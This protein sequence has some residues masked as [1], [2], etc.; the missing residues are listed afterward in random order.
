MMASWRPCPVLFFGAVFLRHCGKR[1]DL[2]LFQSKHALPE[3]L[4]PDLKE[5]LRICH[6]KRRD[7]RSCRH[8]LKDGRSDRKILFHCPEQEKLLFLQ[9][10]HLTFK[11][12]LF[13]S[14]QI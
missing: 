6:A 4:L 13:L 8:H 5:P 14:R 12:K 1:S 10:L 2:S 7:F 11:L 3:K 9:F